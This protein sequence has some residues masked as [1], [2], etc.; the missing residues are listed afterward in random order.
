MG[1][2]FLGGKQLPVSRAC[3]LG[4]KRNILKALPHGFIWLVL[5]YTREGFFFLQNMHGFYAAGVVTG[6]L[7]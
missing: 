7:G 5:E 1:L 6:E 3:S 4:S 2:D